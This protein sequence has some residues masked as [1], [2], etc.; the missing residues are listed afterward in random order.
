VAPALQDLIKYADSYGFTIDKNT[1]ALIDQGIQQGLVSTQTK[2]DS[3]VTNDL[4]MLIAQTLGATIPENL[5][6]LTGQ[7]QQSMT[8]IEGQTG[9]WGN[10]LDRIKGKLAEDLP[11]AVKKLDAEYTDAMTGH[12]I[13]T[14]TEKWQ[15][16]LTNVGDVIS[17]DLEA[18]GIGLD[19]VFGAVMGRLVSYSGELATKLKDTALAGGD[20]EAVFT[21]YA[22]KIGITSEQLKSVLDIAAGQVITISDEMRAKITELTATMG[23]AH[24][25]ESTLMS[26]IIK[27]AE[28]NVSNFDTYAQRTREILTDYQTGALDLKQTQAAMGG[29]FNEL[30]SKAKELGTEGSK[31]MV[32]MLKDVRAAG[33]EIAEM[34]DYVN[35]KLNSGVE[36]LDKYISSF[37]STTTLSTEYG[38][39]NKQLDANLEALEKVEAEMQAGGKTQEELNELKKEA[40]RLEAERTKLLD[41]TIAKENELGAAQKDIESNWDF[42]QAAALS[43]FKALESEGHSFVEIVGMMD[44]QLTN[45]SQMA[46]ENGLSISDGLKEMTD[47]ADFVKQNEGLSNRIDATRQMMEAL[48]DTAYLSGSDFTMFADQTK[49][50]FDDIIAKGGDSKMALRLMAPALEDLVKYSESYGYTIDGNTQALIDQAREQGLMSKQQKTDAQVTNDIL[51]L[52]AETLGA[53]IPESMK[54]MT[55]AMSE[56]VDNID[57]KTQDISDTVDGVS[58]QIST[59]LTDAVAG[60]EEVFEQVTGAI[61]GQLSGLGQIAVEKGAEVQEGL[62]TMTDKEA[63]AEYTQAMLSDIEN[64]RNEMAYL[65]ESAMLTDD[66][67]AEFS[68]RTVERFMDMAS[69]TGDSEEAL[70]LLGPAFDDITKYADQYGFTIDKNTQSL[71][72]QAKEQDLLAKKTEDETKAAN[73]HLEE[74][75]KKYG[76]EL[77]DSLKT[78]TSSVEDEMKD[79]KK[80]T[81]GWTESLDDVKDKMTEELPKAI[82]SLDD[83]YTDAMTGHSIVTETGKWKSSLEDVNDILGRELLETAEN[84]NGKYKHVTGNIYEY[85]Q[86]TSKGGYIARLSFD[87]MV[88]ELERLK[89]S[90]DTMALKKKLSDKDKNIM[91]DY[92]RQIEELSEA[93]EETAPTLENFGKKFKEFQDQLSGDIGVNRGMIE[94]ARGLR[95][96]GQSLEEIDDLIDKSLSGGAK[97]LGAWV[98]ALGPAQKEIEE[99]K[100][101]QDEINEL[102]GKE[103]VKEDELVKLQEMEA[104]LLKRRTDAQSLFLKDQEELLNSQDL[105]VSYFHSMRAEGKSVSE[106]MEVLGD[107]FE[108]LAQKSMAEL[109]GEAGFE[110]TET[111]SNLY[112]MQQKMADNGDLVKGIEGLSEALHGMGDSM[113]YMSDEEFGRFQKSAGSAFEK[114]KTAGFDEV[115]SLQLIAPMLHDLESYATEYGFALDKSTAGLLKEAK[116][117][118][119]LREKQKSDTEKLVEVNEQLAKVMERVASSLE[120]MGK[121]SPFAQMADEVQAL[122]QQTARLKGFERKQKEVTSEIELAKSQA[123]RLINDIATAGG[124]TT[125]TGAG[126][127]SQLLLKEDELE[128]LLRKQADIEKG[129]AQTKLLVEKLQIE[130]NKSMPATENSYVSA[131]LGFHGVLPVDKWFRL[132]QG[133]RVDVWT[134]EETQKIQATPIRR[135]NLSDE[136]P[137]RARRGDI[138]FEH[139]TI[140][141]ENGEEAVREFMTAIKGNKYGVQNLIRKVSQ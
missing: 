66:Q 108:N 21:E 46:T 30:L 124:V 77:P 63:L 9:A 57:Q 31:Q 14:E 136:N 24:A 86:K 33:L 5:Q 81:T 44:G 32:A 135:M 99:L 67:F 37:K 110:M 51:L 38:D 56:S 97:G 93:I 84:L 104:D 137:A 60:Q 132:H 91:E 16:A 85:L 28:I 39:L 6:N 101:L 105:V 59:G 55:D 113:L 20:L 75:A 127:Y 94:M 87:E 11:G 141:S 102:R 43:T 82:K 117:G 26:D 78:L 47:M 112:N 103:E 96:Q 111:F 72:D 123:Q 1:Q 36:A 2:T 140:Q 107:S 88:K 53:T 22:G 68:Q 121:V 29:A 10:S 3:Q 41:D 89:N 25:A 92:K 79:I 17:K 4:L 13:V 76:L 42:M 19:S 18:R 74:M 100:K 95:E 45:L 106:I 133:E 114:L 7:M 126:L 128:T 15:T 130:Y 71:I 49:S 98:N 58:E 70:K 80:E 35:D 34:Q 83:K 139:I 23:N 48:G 50:Q 134:S 119:I 90:Y 129:Y 138:V 52:I 122:D 54:S 109:T 131:A 73:A 125:K 8:V 115:Q 27:D 62:K 118:G 40:A 120:T 61:E 65:G 12:S 69:K 116:E 64:T